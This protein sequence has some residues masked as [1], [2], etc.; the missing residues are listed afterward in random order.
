MAPFG[1]VCCGF[2]RCFRRGE[3]VTNPEEDLEKAMEEMIDCMEDIVEIITKQQVEIDRLAQL[4][5][6]SNEFK[7]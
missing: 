6:K 3:E 7:K 5:I 4:I 1:Y 2:G